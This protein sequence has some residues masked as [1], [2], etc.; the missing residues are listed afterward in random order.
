MFW[1]AGARIRTPGKSIFYVWA[2]ANNDTLSGV[3]LKLNSFQFT[4]KI[5]L[6]NKY[7]SKIDRLNLPQ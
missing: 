7:L 5:P 1:V 2:E 3:P 4:A 6:L